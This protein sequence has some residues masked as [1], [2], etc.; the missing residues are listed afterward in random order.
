MCLKKA[1]QIPRMAFF[2]Q[3]NKGDQS[4][5]NT[6]VPTPIDGH[7]PTSSPL[8]AEHSS[9]TSAPCTS[10]PD[11]PGQGL[12]DRR[13]LQQIT[14]NPLFTDMEKIFAALVKGGAHERNRFYR[15]VGGNWNDPELDPLKRAE[16]A[17]NAERVLEYI[18]KLNGQHSTPYNGHLEGAHKNASRKAPHKFNTTYARSEARRLLDFCEHGFSIFTNLPDTAPSPERPTRNTGRA[19]GDN[20]SAE[21]ITRGPLFKRLLS[22]TRNGRSTPLLEGHRIE[23]FYLQIGGDWNDK[24]LGDRERA[25]I[26]ANAERVLN[27]IDSLGGHQSTASD[28]K[29]SGIISTRVRLAYEGLT[30]HQ[31]SIEGS[32]ARQLLNFVDNGYS[33]F[34]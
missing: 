1:I 3:S 25:D 29:I 28:Q 14:K 17:A 18:D 24:T 27:Y 32:E 15:H 26:A 20:R 7:N 4:L 23:K 12:Y 2:F 6:T 34:E 13:S 33:A 30:V 11:S 21:E 22:A 16:W 19:T 10:P 8:P 9:S 5:R 31:L